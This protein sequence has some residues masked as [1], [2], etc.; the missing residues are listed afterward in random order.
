MSDDNQTTSNELATVAN[1]TPE[2]WG[3]REEVAAI[4]RRLRT[5]LPNGARMT[6][7][8]AM[9]AAQY[10][11]LTGLDPFTGG[12]YILPEGG[13][14]DNYKVL[15][16]W[17]QNREPF[18][19]KYFPLTNE[20]RTEEGMTDAVEAWKCYI[21]KRSQQPLMVQMLQ[22]GLSVV[23]VLGLIATKGIGMVEQTDMVTKTGQKRNPPKGWT[24]VGVAKK[25]ALK[26]AIGFAY[27]MPTIPELRRLGEQMGSNGV[28]M[29]DPDLAR[30]AQLLGTAQQVQQNSVGMTP[31]QRASRLQQNRELMH[32]PADV[33]IGEFVEVDSEAE[34]YS[35]ALS[36]IPYYNH[37]NH[38]KN[39]L[40]KLGLEYDAAN[41]DGLIE[42]LKIYASQSADATANGQMGFGL[43]VPP[44]PAKNAV[45]E[46]L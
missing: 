6:T 30:A 8:Q 19:E 13:I 24:W 32:G 43:D 14:A 17:A 45:K 2:L 9:A 36:E 28:A 23:E 35:H 27:G 37:V 31:E 12:F 15:T 22:L 16:A 42:E 21:V 34:F 25:R 18:T 41:E 1:V 26:N 38:I 7:E 3:D 29:T 11:K 44:P 46:G 10:A 39:A 33:T 4:S 20:E 40:N 5:M